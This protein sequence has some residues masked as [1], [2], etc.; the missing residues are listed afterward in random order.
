MVSVCDVAKYILIQSG[1]M[2]AMKL[3]KLVYY[4]QAWS[5]VW[6]EKA[7]F[8]EEIEAWANGPVV[9]TLY[10]AHKG[11]F[12]VTS[13]SLNC[14]A[15]ISRLSQQ[16]KETIAKVLKFYGKKN[17]QW[18]IDL[19]HMEEPWI[20]ARKNANLKE[21]DR[22]SAVISHASMHEYYSGIINK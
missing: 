15:N 19:S 1:E 20:E 2:T 13:D 4:A 21:G 9:R 10:D 22:G 8:R 11:Q 7:M 6:N 12:K 17:A 14:R 3:Q 16:H 18:L 5:L